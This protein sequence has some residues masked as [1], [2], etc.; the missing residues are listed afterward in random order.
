MAIG[1]K[2]LPI[3]YRVTA[4]NATH[5]IAL[6]MRLFGEIGGATLEGARSKSLWAWLSRYLEKHSKCLE[7]IVV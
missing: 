4:C 7:I 3:Y 6:T 5:G 1:L 2:L